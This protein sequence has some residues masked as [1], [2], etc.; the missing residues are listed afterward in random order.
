VPQ[1]LF[2][3]IAIPF[4]EL[5][6]LLMLSARMGWP[7]TLGLVVVTGIVGATLA[8]L[9]GLRTIQKLQQEVNDGQMPTTALMDAA[10]ILVAGALLLTPG[11]LTDIFGFSLLI[12]VCRTAYRNALTGYIKRNFKVTTVNFQN[13]HAGPVVDGTVVD[14]SPAADSII[15]VQVI[16]SEVISKDR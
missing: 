14:S 1:L 12:P 11:I 8:K 4:V 13:M 5:V 7:M 3:F 6:L 16:D 15:D 10:M 9:Q 2:L